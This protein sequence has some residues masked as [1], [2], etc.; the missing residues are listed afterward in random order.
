MTTKVARMLEL[1]NQVD[2]QMFQ[3]AT[4]VAEHFFTSLV[5]KS[6][7]LVVIHTHIKA[8]LATLTFSVSSYVSTWAWLCALPYPSAAAAATHR[9][10]TTS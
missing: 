9:A 2:R 6:S 5:D 10:S 3:A 8:T 4:K 7:L 1:V